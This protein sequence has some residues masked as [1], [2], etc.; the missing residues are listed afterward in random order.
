MAF[1]ILTAQEA[2]EMI[3]NG[4]TVGLSGFTAPGTPKFITEALA[5]KA[6]REHEAGRPFKINLFS[7]ASM[8]A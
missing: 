1:N 6:V 5:E 4:D 7:A 3:K 2:A 8:M